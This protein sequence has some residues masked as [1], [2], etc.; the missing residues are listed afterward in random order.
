MAVEKINC[1]ENWG[2]EDFCKNIE[3]VHSIRTP[4]LY[5]EFSTMKTTLNKYL[6]LVMELLEGQSRRFDLQFF[7]QKNYTG[8][9]L[10]TLKLF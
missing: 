1:G 8:L 6:F 9:M 5:S 10:H 3:K 4:S 2:E 7:H